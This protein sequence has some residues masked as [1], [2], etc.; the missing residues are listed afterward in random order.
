M[1]DDKIQ[2]LYIGIRGSTKLE[3]LENVIKDSE[4]ILAEEMTDDIPSPFMS[5]TTFTATCDLQMSKASRKE[6]RKFLITDRPW[7][8]KYPNKKRK[9]RV[10]KKWFNRYE[11]PLLKH[12]VYD[13]PFGEIEVYSATLR[14]AGGHNKNVEIE[15]RPKF[16]H[17]KI[18]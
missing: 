5:P 4:L 6:L 14:K 7:N 18:L 1:D 11:K 3:P 16:Y 10:V 15:A 12:G 2:D 9:W 17:L 8:L 13:T